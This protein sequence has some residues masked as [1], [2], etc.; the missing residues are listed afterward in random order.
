M[1]SVNFIYVTPQALAVRTI[2]IHIW[3]KPAGKIN[4]HCSFNV[5]YSFVIDRAVD[6]M[7]T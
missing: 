3:E 5:L 6:D 7:T 4:K 2:Q 1:S